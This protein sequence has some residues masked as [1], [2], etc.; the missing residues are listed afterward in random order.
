MRRRQRAVCAAASFL[1]RGIALLVALEAPVAALFDQAVR[2]ATV[3]VR[4]VAVLALWVGVLLAVAAGG[5]WDGRRRR[6]RGGRRHTLSG[7][8]THAHPGRVDGGFV[9]NVAL[10]FPHADDGAVR[11]RGGMH[12]VAALIGDRD[13][14]T[15]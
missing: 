11:Q 1:R 8:G 5:G 10:P 2:V 9:R 12:V 7:I 6:R 3:A 4:L 13:G 14:G 15:E